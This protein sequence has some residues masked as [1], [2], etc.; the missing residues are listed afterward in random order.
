[1]AGAIFLGFFIA[2]INFVVY[3]TIGRKAL[4]G[5]GRRTLVIFVT[6]FIIKFVFIVLLFSFIFY[7]TKILMIPFILSFFI[8][9]YL[10]TGILIKQLA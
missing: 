6:S 8:S 1:M 7:F 10:L 9:Y 3:C 4:Q 2:L 5:F